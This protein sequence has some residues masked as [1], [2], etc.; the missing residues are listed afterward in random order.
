MSRSYLL[1]GSFAYD[2]VFTHPQAFGERIKP[3]AIDK[4]N[5]SLQLD[6]VT[7][8]YGGCAGNIAYNAHLLGDSPL[9]MGHVGH[10][11][12]RYLKRIAGWGLDCANIGVVEEKHTA[13]AWVLT[14]ADGNQLTSFYAG[15]MAEPFSPVYSGALPYSVYGKAPSLWHIAPEDPANMV[16]LAST[17]RQ[18]GA[19][20]FFD[21]GQALPSLLNKE[22]SHISPLSFVL[23]D[24]QGIFLNEYEAELLCSEV[25]DLKHLL[26]GRDQF[27]V[28]TRG[29]KGVDLIRREGTVT[30]PPAMPDQVVDPTGCGDAFR[31]GFLHAYVR[32]RSLEECVAL[33]AVMGALAVGSEGGQNHQASFDDIQERWAHYTQRV[34]S[35]GGALPV[36]TSR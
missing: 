14:D 28:R 7:D 34:S 11:G 21:P 32:E 22:A 1:A 10:D 8:A 19:K 16:R 15:A 3:D 20:Y 24:A 13:H 36:L 12:E 2:T 18:V 5:V 17:A 33:G 35:A 23:M 6:S 25:I 26:A 31:A 29:A 27:I 9:L 4:L 30:L